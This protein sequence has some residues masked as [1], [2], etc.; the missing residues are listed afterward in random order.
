M[1]TIDYRS[2]QPIYEQ[3]RDRLREYIVSGALKEDE[4]MP[5]VRTLASQ[6]AV[7]P[8]TIQRAYRELESEGYLYSVA[9]KGNF[10][11][12]SPDADRQRIEKLK[13]DVVKLLKELRQLGADEE[14][15]LKL[16]REE[17]G[18]D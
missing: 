17:N 14:E 7:N 6:L 13:A 1:L 2:G 15:I 18:D 8:N 9:G 4:K 10:V 5:S 11:S 3:I 16:L 12:R